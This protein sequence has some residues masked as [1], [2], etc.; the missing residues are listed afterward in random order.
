MAKNGIQALGIIRNN[1]IDL[2]VSDIVMPE[3]DGLTLCKTIKSEILTS[4]IPVI[5]LTAKSEMENRIEGLEMGADSYIPKPFHPKHLFVRIE[6]LLK[7]REQ[8]SEYFKANLGTPSYDFQQNYSVRDKDLLEKCVMFIENNFGEETLDAEILASHL[9]LSK[10]Q[11]YRKIK[12]LTGL[13][14]HGLIK[15]FRL[16]KARQMIAEGEYSI[17]EIIYMSGFNNRTYFYRSYKE[18]FGETPGEINKN[19]N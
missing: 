3:M 1:R 4:H 2:L 7:T 9:A 12:A 16:K 18:I 19:V 6:K 10:A 11:L 8:I 15:N 13:T 5:L 14:P 17:T